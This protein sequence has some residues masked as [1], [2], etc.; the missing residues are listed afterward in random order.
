[1][2]GLGKITICTVKAHTLGATEGSM[3]VNITW[4]RNMGMEYTI[5][6]MEEGTKDTGKTG[7]STVKANTFYRTE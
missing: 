2:K 3:R 6:Q 1:M 5:G 7:S 4:T